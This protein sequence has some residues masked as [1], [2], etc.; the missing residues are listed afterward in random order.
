MMFE[1]AD[2]CQYGHYDTTPFVYLPKDAR[3]LRSKL[4][5]EEGFL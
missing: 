2:D 3:A 5:R 4:R 1:N